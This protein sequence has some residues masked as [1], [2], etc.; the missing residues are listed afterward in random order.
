MFI[1]YGL[2]N[3]WIGNVFFIKKNKLDGTTIYDQEIMRPVG[4]AVTADA[5]AGFSLAAEYAVQCA[6]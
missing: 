4:K 3:S 1:V 6:P 5:H 2:L